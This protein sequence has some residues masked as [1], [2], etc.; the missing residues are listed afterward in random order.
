MGLDMYLYR[1]READ[2]PVA[3][4]FDKLEAAEWS[5]EAY[6][7]LKADIQVAYWRKA[8]AIHGWFVDTCQGGEDECQFSEPIGR[9]ALA[10]LVER[11]KRVLSDAAAPQDALPTRDG[12]FFGGDDYDEWYR[13]GLQETIAQ[14]E[15]LL[16]ERNTDTFIYRSSW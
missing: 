6:D 14:I 10:G 11:C 3:E 12:F 4:R 15:P 1:Q 13:E 9:E 8:N 7:A 2:A 5:P 16:A